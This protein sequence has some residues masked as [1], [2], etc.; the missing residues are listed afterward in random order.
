M[1]KDETNPKQKQYCV[2]G[3][4]ARIFGGDPDVRR[5]MSDQEAE[6]RFAKVWADKLEALVRTAPVISAEQARE[7]LEEKQRTYVTEAGQYR[8]FMIDAVPIV[9]RMNKDATENGICDQIWLL[10]AHRDPSRLCMHFE[11]V[12]LKEDFDQLAKSLGY[13]PR[14]LALELVM[15]FM[16][17]HPKREAGR[18]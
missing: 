7:L 18:R 3:G 14:I 12:A 5:R 17:K 9:V 2:R 15:D 16:R 8:Q 1:I 10:G 13:E 4:D 11:T 6:E